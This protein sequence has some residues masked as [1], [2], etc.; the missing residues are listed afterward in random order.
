[1]SAQHLSSIVQ[2]KE[3]HLDQRTDDSKGS[4]S[5]VLEWPSLASSVQEWIQEQRD[6]S[7]FRLQRS[8]DIRKYAPPEYISL[9]VQEQAP[10][11]CMTRNAL[12]QRQSVTNSITRMCAQTRRTQCWIDINDLQQ[13]RTHDPESSPEHQREIFV[14]FPLLAQL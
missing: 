10:R 4:Q 9:T 5:E 8:A 2:T 11:L 3:A 12:Q 6:M 1:M 14:H 7:C 13:E